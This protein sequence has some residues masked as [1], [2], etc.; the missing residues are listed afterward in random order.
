MAATGEVECKSV[1]FMCK[2]M[3]KTGQT[4]TSL[5]GGINSSAG[6]VCRKAFAGLQIRANW[7]SLSDVYYH[8]F[9]C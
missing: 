3:Q 9:A 4:A 8:I 2:S 1:K 7:R 5:E 6:A